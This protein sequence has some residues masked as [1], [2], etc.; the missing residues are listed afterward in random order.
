MP[1]MI[2]LLISGIFSF[3][4]AIMIFVEAVPRRRKLITGVMST[5][6]I[7]NVMFAGFVAYVT[8]SGE[9]FFGVWIV[10]VVFNCLFQ[11]IYNG[12]KVLK[13]EDDEVSSSKLG[14]IDTS[15]VEKASVS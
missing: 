7:I 8:Q 4:Q 13:P 9:I 2:L 12:F 10:I 14:A 3:G 15:A 5:F 11:L 6:K 1:S